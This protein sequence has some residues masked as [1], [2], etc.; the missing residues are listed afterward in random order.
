MA[1][2][3]GPSVMHINHLDGEPANNRRDNLEYCTPQ[4]N[5]RHTIDVL[6]R[7]DGP[8]GD[9]NY[10]AVRPNVG[11]IVSLDKTGLSH[12]AIARE[13]GLNCHKLVGVVLRG[14]HWTQR[15]NVNALRPR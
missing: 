15:E 7:W 11:Q 2:F 5:S 6:K 3:V 10:H 9:R 4:Q 12:R 13:L 8:K 1:A 14:E